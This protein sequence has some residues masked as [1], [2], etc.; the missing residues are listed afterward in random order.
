MVEFLVIIP[1][2]TKLRGK[3]RFLRLPDL[4][5]P[6]W[7][8]R[9]EMKV[10]SLLA[11]SIPTLTPP[12]VPPSN[13]FTAALAKVYINVHASDQGVTRRERDHTGQLDGEVR[14]TDLASAC[15]TYSGLWFVEP[16]FM[17]RA[18]LTCCCIASCCQR[19]RILCIDLFNH[20]DFLGII[21]SDAS[22][23]GPLKTKVIK[24][25]SENTNQALSSQY[26]NFVSSGQPG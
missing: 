13:C 1:H 3:H 24:Y 26:S 16:Y 15:L 19:K 8:G 25:H 20:T 22:A 7:C 6:A 11:S 23:L 18:L 12:V 17:F 10:N 2:L 5:K 9:T 14:G 21:V 4:A